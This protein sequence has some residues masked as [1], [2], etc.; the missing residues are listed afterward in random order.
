MTEDIV[1]VGA[2][3]VGRMVRQ[4]LEDCNRAGANWNFCGFLDANPALH[5]SE[6]HGAPILGDL[7]WLAQHPGAAVALAIGAP[8]ARQ[9]TI[10]HVQRIARP[11]IA[12]L[13]HPRAWI[14]DRVTIGAGVIIYPDVLIDCDVTIHDYALINKTCTIGHDTVIHPFVTMAPGVK[15]G[16]TTVIGE[17]C[18]LG[19]NSAT[20]QG[21]Q[22]GAWSVIGA[23]AAVVRSLPANIT[24]VGVPARVIR[25]REPGWQL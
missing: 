20:I 21:L 18:D 22:I 13:I 14:S 6:L 16:G 5:G 3:A 23:G 8:A 9:R 25:S 4:I 7:T 10:S 12:T 24:A 1:I 17:G 19:I 15:L 11:K 2:G